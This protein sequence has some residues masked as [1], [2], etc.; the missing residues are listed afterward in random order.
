[1]YRKM[2]AYLHIHNTWECCHN[3]VMV[4]IEIDNRP[5]VGDIFWMGEEIQEE[6]QRQ[7]TEYV[8]RAESSYQRDAY[9]ERNERRPFGICI[10]DCVCVVKTVWKRHNDGKFY[11]HFELHDEPEI[12]D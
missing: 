12:D 5:M 6:L 3:E 11:L 4:E 10:D 1:M 8:N 9:G 7:I 2:K